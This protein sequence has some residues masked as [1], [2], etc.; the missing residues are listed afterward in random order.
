MSGYRACL[1]VTVVCEPLPSVYKISSK[2]VANRL[3]FDA[4]TDTN[5]IQYYVKKHSILHLT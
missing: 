1:P 5:L 4:D 2:T 3:D